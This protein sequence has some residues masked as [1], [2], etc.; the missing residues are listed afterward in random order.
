MATSIDQILAEK[1]IDLAS[2]VFEQKQN[3][4]ILPQV[5]STN[6]YIQ[7]AVQQLREPW[8]PL[9]N[10]PVSDEL[11]QKCVNDVLGSVK[12]EMEF[13]SGLMIAPKDNALRTIIV[14]MFQKRQFI[15]QDTIDSICATLDKCDQP[16]NL[17]CIE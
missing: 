6:Y 1:K 2:I 15:D 3:L 16:M 5:L 13:R 9:T 7:K 12:T 8:A 10:Q 14:K 4:V 17:D 11:L